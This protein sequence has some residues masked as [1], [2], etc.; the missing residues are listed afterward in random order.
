MYK[1]NHQTISFIEWRGY[2]Y[3]HAKGEIWKSLYH[4]HCDILLKLLL[5][6]SDTCLE[7]FYIFSDTTEH[8]SGR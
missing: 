5:L 3:T 7:T 8:K 2:F 6:Y 1:N 4:Q